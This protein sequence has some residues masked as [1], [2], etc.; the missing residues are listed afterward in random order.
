MMLNRLFCRL[1]SIS[2]SAVSNSLEV[3]FNAKLLQKLLTEF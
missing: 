2:K 1:V 3:T